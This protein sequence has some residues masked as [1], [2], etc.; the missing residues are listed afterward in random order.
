MPVTITTLVENTPGE[1]LGLKNEHGI[2]FCIQRDGRT[3]LFDVGQTGAFL[4]NA[5]LLRIDLSRVDH[6][7]LSHGHY[8]H[9]GGLPALAEKTIRFNLH[10]G[11][12][13][14]LPKYGKI[15]NSYEYLGNSFD[16]DF[17][18]EKG[19]PFQTESEPV[20]EILPG[21][22][23]FSSFPRVHEDEKISPRFQIRKNG[24]FAQ[25][26]FDDEIAMGVDTK[27]GLVVLLGCSHPGMK[28]MIDAAAARLHKPVYAVYG[29]T[30]L[31]E[32]SPESLELSV[33][34]LKMNVLGVIGMSHCTG[35]TATDRLKTDSLYVRNRTGS[36]H[37][38]D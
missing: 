6:V 27:Q 29:G 21:I 23:V 28:N 37:F 22:F 12:G 4:Q 20:K 36:S 17:L 32:A 2:S 14:F 25:D 10:F 9:S 31:V 13:F 18:A 19:I 34:Y 1:H 24:I 8:D 33:R 5:E 38:F 30:H 3:V 7:V 26:P 35:E 16:E 15:N 11:P